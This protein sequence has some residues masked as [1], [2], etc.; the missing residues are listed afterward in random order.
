[1]ECRSL[2]GTAGR[3]SCWADDDAQTPWNSLSL[4]LVLAA[5]D[6]AQRVSSLEQTQE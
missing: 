6:I 2:H 4:V 1:M 3:L 5:Q